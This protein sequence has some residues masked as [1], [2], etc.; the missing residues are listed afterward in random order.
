[1]ANLKPLPAPILLEK[2]APPRGSENV[3]LV[4]ETFNRKEFN[5]TINTNF[6]ELGVSAAQ[7]RDLSFF[8][9]NL[10]TVGDFFT[11]YQNLFYSIPKG[12]IISGE[13]INSHIFLIERSTAY[14]NFISQQEEID[15]LSQ[16]ITDLRTQN[17]ELVA[18]MANIVEGFEQ[19]VANLTE[20][21][22]G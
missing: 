13:E 17:L 11:I 20:Q 5:D 1:M 2:D 18:D 6:T 15:A 21:I 16:E 12:N 9:P 19:T 7:D 8:D 4:R 3:Q 10:A 14:T 22:N